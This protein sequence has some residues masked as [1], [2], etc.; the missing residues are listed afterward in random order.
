VKPL[1]KKEAGRRYVLRQTPAQTRATRMEANMSHIAEGSYDPC[2]LIYL[3]G[4]QW[5]KIRI[6]NA[7]AD[8][9]RAQLARLSLQQV[10]SPFDPRC[11]RERLREDRSAAIDR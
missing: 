7:F 1:T 2:R 6:R 10:G 3:L 4:K 5:D 11:E 8:A 9:R